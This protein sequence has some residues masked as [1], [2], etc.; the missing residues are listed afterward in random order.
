MSN[1]RV[2][3][4]KPS[5]EF[6]QAIKKTRGVKNKYPWESIAEG[7]NLFISPQNGVKLKTIENLAYKAG[8]KLKKVFKVVGYDNGWIEVG[9]VEK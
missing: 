4:G 9:L 1:D 7:N 5:A 2:I 6:M 8:R 3:F